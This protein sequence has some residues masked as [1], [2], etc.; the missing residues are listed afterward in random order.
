MA[1]DSKRGGAIDGAEEVLE[2]EMEVLEEGTRAR[3]REFQKHLDAITERGRKWDKGM[4]EE[5]DERDQADKDLRDKVTEWLENSWQDI[6]DETTTAFDNYENEIFPPIEQR[7]TDAEIGFK[8]FEEVTVPTMMD[9]LQ[10]RVARH[11]HKQRE[12]FDIDNIKLEKREKKIISRFIVHQHRSR[13]AFIDEER[14]RFNK[15]L[16]FGEE[17][18]ETGRVDDRQDE[19]LQC[20]VMNDMAM[21]KD[22]LLAEGLRR[23]DEDCDILDNLAKSMARLQKSVLVNFGMGSS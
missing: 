23:E 14:T 17:M 19:V 6:E 20:K 12:A 1:P 2:E 5:V 7:C 18:D 10:G 13:Q 15:L 11:L 16:V 21:Q 9:E 4:R 8:E 3:N 22:L